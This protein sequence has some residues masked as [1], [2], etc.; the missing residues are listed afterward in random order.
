M[1]VSKNVESLLRLS[2]Q[3]L[4]EF[5]VCFYVGTGDGNTKTSKLLKSKCKI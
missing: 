3:I 1:S 5:D 2:K 4:N